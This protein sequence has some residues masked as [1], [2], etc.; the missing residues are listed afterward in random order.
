MHL[1]GRSLHAFT[2]PHGL[3]PYRDR[4]LPRDPALHRGLAL[5]GGLALLASPLAT[6]PADASTGSPDTVIVRTSDEQS[7]AATARAVEAAGGTVTT[8]LH[9]VFPGLVA[10]LTPAQRQRIASLPGVE[11]VEQDQQTNTTSTQQFGNNDGYGQDDGQWGLDMSDERDGGLDHAYSTTRDGSGVTAYV[12]DTG[13]DAGNTDFAGRIRSGHDAV[14]DGNGT[15]DCNGHGTHMSGLVGGT[16]YGIAKRVTLV[17]VRVQSCDYTS[18]T[19]RYLEG[20]DWMI[21]DHQAGTPAV[22][23]MSFDEDPSELLDDAVKAAGADGITVVIAA[24]NTDEGRGDDS[25]QVSPGRASATNGS[26]TVGGVQLDVD[27]RATWYTGGMGG[28]CI[29][30]LAPAYNL[31]SDI[32]GG[33][34]RIESGTSQATALT[35]GV[36]ALVLQANPH[37]TPAQVKQAIV[38][39]STQGVVHNVPGGVPNRLLFSG[40]T[41]TQQSATTPVATQSPSATASAA[42]KASATSTATARAAASTAPTSHPSASSTTNAASST[43]S[44]PSLRATA[45]HL[46]GTSRVGRLVTAVGGTTSP[47][48]TSRTV[49]WYR[50]AGSSRVLVGTGSSHLLTASERGTR[51]QACVTS[52]RPGYRGTTACSGWSW[53][54]SPGQFTL[55]KA[56]VV[57]G[58]ARVGR[59]LQATAGSWNPSPSLVTYRWYRVDA[60]GRATAI[61]GATGSRHLVV[62]ADRG[63]R[64]RVV[65]GVART[66]WSSR[67]VAATTGSIS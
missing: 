54:A 29:D 32:P 28:S 3:A 27:N 17:P 19:S 37:A 11:A 64:L 59:T 51:L 14:G 22:A 47:A 20:I 53:P 43:T 34:S 42:P 26:I 4:T 36:A 39:Q 7:L 66:G 67:S 65:V 40:A 16:T 41:I 45:V 9:H 1:D 6:T 8:E 31:R 12:V 24:G 63:K 15:S 50:Q 18:S 21:A 62:A 23:N 61:T 44:T 35:S 13:I 57:Q 58:T 2:R 55:V 30:L 48:A 5:V 10:R 49:R 38:G 25:C 56:P 33:G 52:S 60:K 46:A